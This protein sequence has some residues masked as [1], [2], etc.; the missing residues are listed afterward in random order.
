MAKSNPKQSKE[1]FYLDMVSVLLAAGFVWSV[2]SNAQD[3]IKSDI[4]NA[5]ATWALIL[6]VAR[7]LYQLFKRRSILSP[8]NIVALTM[9]ATGGAIWL[10]GLHQ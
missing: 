8:L 10:F 6:V 7:N 1:L 9:L 2:C 5:P 3:L 4:A